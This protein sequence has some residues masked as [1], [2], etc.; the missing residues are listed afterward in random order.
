MGLFFLH[1]SSSWV[2]IRLHAEFEL[3]RMYRRGKSA[4]WGLILS[5]YNYRTLFFRI[6]TCRSIAIAHGR[7]PEET[8]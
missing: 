5:R 6:K 1:I 2:E 4:I 8:M 7:D 3:L